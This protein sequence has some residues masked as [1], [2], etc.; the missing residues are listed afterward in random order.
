V[1]V[2]QLAEAC[3]ADCTKAMAY[4]RLAAWNC[5]IF[6]T[7]TGAESPGGVDPKEL[8]KYATTEPG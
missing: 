3:H 6:H 4:A 2:K 8:L 5:G 1:R 7:A